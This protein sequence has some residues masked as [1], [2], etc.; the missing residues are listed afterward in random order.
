VSDEAKD[1][2]TRVIIEI[3]YDFIASRKRE[4]ITIR[5]EKRCR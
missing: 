5:T 1:L 3:F 2:I 4:K